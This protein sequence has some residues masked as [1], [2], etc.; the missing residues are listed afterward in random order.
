[1]AFYAVWTGFQKCC[2]QKSIFIEIS[3]WLFDFCVTIM[4]N[5]FYCRT[6]AELKLDGS[7]VIKWTAVQFDSHAVNFCLVKN[8]RSKQL[9]LQT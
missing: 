3:K 9:I 2:I 4:P 7:E 8:R 1:M 5:A 6:S